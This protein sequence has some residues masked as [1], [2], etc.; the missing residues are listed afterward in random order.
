MLAL[1][2]YLLSGVDSGFD[3]L[4]AVVLSVLD[5]SID[6]YLLSGV[7]VSIDKLSVAQG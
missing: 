1:I 3:K 2:N 4:P 7:D 5:V 6:K